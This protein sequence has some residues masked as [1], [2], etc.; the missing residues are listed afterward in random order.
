V[1][2][3][4]VRTD[5]PSGIS[6]AELDAL[7]GRV[8]SLEARLADGESRWKSVAERPAAADD[9]RVRALAQDLR[10]LREW[11]EGELKAV[12]AQFDAVGRRIDDA[13]AP[14]AASADAP[15]TPE[16]ED[17]W[18]TLARDTDGGV[19][20][21]AL[22]KL[23][24]M[25]TDRSVHASVERLADDDPK[26]V[27]QALRNLGKFRE[28]DTAPQVAVALDHA[29]SVVR[30]A[31]YAALLDMGAPKDTG[32]DANETSAEKR[33]PAVAALKAWAESR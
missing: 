19:R 4:H 22:Q 20:F 10:A 32:F 33:K 30:T 17:R 2:A 8:A 28:A 1:V 27:W 24:R 26:V 6:R 15:L 12:D 13:N 23:G 16:E 21:S 3:G 5:V 25:R 9:E 18:A 14:F 11:A 29:E 7:A 31:A